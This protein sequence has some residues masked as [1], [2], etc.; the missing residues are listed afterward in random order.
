MFL[1]AQQRAFLSG[2][3]RGGSPPKV[4]AS[5]VFELPGGAEANVT[6][7]EERGAT[8]FA[9]SLSGPGD[10][11]PPADAARALAARVAWR[12]RRRAGRAPAFDRGAFPNRGRDVC[13]LCL[14]L[15]EAAGDAG[16][17]AVGRADGGRVAVSVDGRLEWC[18][19]SRDG[20]DALARPATFPLLLRLCRR[21]SY[22][23]YPT[24]GS[25]WAGMI[26]DELAR[27]GVDR[28]VVSFRRRAGNPERPR[29][30]NVDTSLTNRGDAAALGGAD[31]PRAGRAAGRPLWRSRSPR[32]PGRGTVSPSCTTSVARRSTR[33]ATRARVPT[34]SRRWSRRALAERQP[35][36]FAGKTSENGFRRGRSRSKTFVSPR[37][38]SRRS[39]TAAAN[40][41][42][43][44]CEAD[45]DGVGVLFLTADRPAD[46]RGVAA[47]QASTRA[48]FRISPKILTASSV[49]D[50]RSTNASGR[51]RETSWVPPRS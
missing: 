21:N 24:A 22:E 30:R 45:A 16:A 7:V 12:P 8:T 14:D 1:G 48:A 4:A 25:A 6:L 38:G 43:A 46:A 42:P 40:L 31:S 28:F 17:A 37:S 3:L 51:R 10:E 34:R 39:G 9:V 50:A 44:A 36:A 29:K 11:A 19:V 33:S 49:E 26:V 41:L 23:S 5:C 18:D 20:E 2:E 47:D 32:T 15:L 27:Q 35:P 13:A